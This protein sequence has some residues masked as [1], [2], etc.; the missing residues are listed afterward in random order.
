MLHH[1]EK[2]VRK[3]LGELNIA[4]VVQLKDKVWRVA[5]FLKRL[6]AVTK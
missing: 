5:A 4:Q 2:A 1:A 6:A 3:Y